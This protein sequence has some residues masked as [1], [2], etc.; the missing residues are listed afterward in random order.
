MAKST[1]IGIIGLGHIGST[2][3]QEINAHPEW[4]IEVGFV[5]DF[6]SSRT[7]EL[8]GEQVL[9]KLEDFAAYDVDLVCELAHSDISFQYGTMFLEK[10]DYFM[11]SVTAI[12]DAELEQSLRQTA[13]KHGTRVW[14]PHGGVAIMDL[15]YECRDIFDQVKL[16]MIKPPQNLDWSRSGVDPATITKRTVLH[17][18]PVREVCKRFPRNVNTLAAAA[19]AGKGLDE[20]TAILIADPAE[21]KAR[22][23]IYAQGGGV[24]M[25]TTRAEDIEGVT[26]A[27]TPVSVMNSI[28]KSV[29]AP[30]G[31]HLC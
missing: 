19:F 25:V 17:D 1:R 30:P 13:Q 6:D 21:T 9:E 18:G 27:A 14:V 28:R 20:T 23:N 15:L 2:I 12:A 26:G 11:L 5:H 7:S 3:Y 10:A 29:A 8:P 4:N 31:L 24:D 22:V 16:E